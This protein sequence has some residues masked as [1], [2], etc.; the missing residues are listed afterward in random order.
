M[1]NFIHI[2]PSTIQLEFSDVH[3]L[4]SILNIKNITNS[5]VIIKVLTNRKER[6]SVIPPVGIIEPGKELKVTIQATEFLAYEEESSK[7]KF[8]IS[9]VES[10][11]DF[12]LKELRNLL[13]FDDLEGFKNCLISNQ[14][15]LENNID[16]VVDSSTMLN[17]YEQPTYQQIRTSLDT[18]RLQ[19]LLA[20][21]NEKNI[22]LEEQFDELK[23]NYN[24]ELIDGGMKEQY[25]E[26]LM[27]K[28]KELKK[29]NAHLLQVT[30]N[31]KRDI[32]NC[33]KR[34]STDNT[35]QVAIQTKREEKQNFSAKP[36]DLAIEMNSSSD[37]DSVSIFSSETSDEN[38]LIEHVEVEFSQNNQKQ[39]VYSDHFD[40]HVFDNLHDRRINVSE[41]VMG[42]NT[43]SVE[44]KEVLDSHKSNGVFSSEHGS[45]DT[46]EKGYFAVLILIFFLG[47]LAGHFLKRK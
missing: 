39:N 29:Q 27:L 4:Q 25:I 23:Q 18:Q 12:I 7:D 41:R 38:H 17:N 34:E 2:T 30:Q 16:L 37:F 24:K 46:A 44:N 32:N 43:R 10:S 14:L 20:D 40:R 5:H 1:N 42:F 31:L 36:V 28:N 47:I 21:V 8:R 35:G 45:F 33:C 3:D 22:Q 9:C 15:K 6:Y 13:K 26:Q 11:D 19:N